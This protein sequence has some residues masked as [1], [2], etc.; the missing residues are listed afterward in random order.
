ME[1]EKVGM[2]H[3]PEDEGG[4]ANND[5][6]HHK[7]PEELQEA[8]AAATAWPEVGIPGWDRLAVYSRPRSGGLDSP[9]SL[10]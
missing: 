4:Q 8:A 6:R 2:E 9:T 10:A 1:F 5:Y 3:E 7:E